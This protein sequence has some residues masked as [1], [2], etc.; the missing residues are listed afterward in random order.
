MT[1]REQSKPKRTAGTA[2]AA[3]AKN[4]AA[5]GSAAGIGTASATGAQIAAAVGTAGGKRGRPPKFAGV[6]RQNFSFRVTEQTRQLLIAGA[7][8]SGRSLS[9][10]IEF[11][12]NRDLNWEAT[13]RDIEKMSA[14]A[15]A[16]RSAARVRAIREAGF[17][18]LRDIEGSPNRVIVTTEMLL[19]EAD[20]IQRSGFIPEPSKS[21]KSIKNAG[22][23]KR[24]QVP[25]PPSKI[26]HTIRNVKN[27]EIEADLQR[28]EG[29]IAS[30]RAKLVDDNA[31]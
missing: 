3:G 14:E 26:P 23:K 25:P 5:K 20:E 13:K 22:K 15:A 17:Q 12:L 1:K 31:A 28:I 19:G 9:E 7:T 24:L 18:L 21:V 16:V 2:S 11:R 10:E 6:K 29:L 30:T 27:A 4:A 8:A